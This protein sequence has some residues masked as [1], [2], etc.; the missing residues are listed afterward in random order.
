MKKPAHNQAVSDG[1]DPQDIIRVLREKAWLILACAVVGGALGSAYITRSPRIF[2]SREVVQVE[3]QAQNVINIQQVTSEELQSSEIV[4]T[5]EQN[6]V[7]LTLF[8]RVAKAN[9]LTG[10]GGELAG[11]ITAKI[12]TGTRLIDITAEDQNPEMAQKLAHSVVT[13]FVRQNA[14]ASTASTET[15]SRFLMEEAGQLKAKLE[16]SEQ[17]LQRYKEQTQAVSL[18]ERQ[19]ITV[20][21][22]K[23]LNRRVTEAKAERLRLESDSAEVQT[24]AGNPEQLCKISTVVANPALLDYRKIIATQ[25]TEVAGLSER[26][27]A[28]HPKMIQAKAQLANLRAGL[29]AEI[30]RAATA[31]VG[32]YEESKTTEQKFE[33]ALHE[34][35]QAALSLNKLSIPYNVLAREVESDRALY[36]SVLKRMKETDVT[37]GLEPNSVRIVEAASLPMAPI[38]PDKVRIFLLAVVG[39]LFLGFGLAFGFNAMDGSFKSVE[40][41]ETLLGMPVLG[42]IPQHAGD[43]PLVFRESDSRAAESFRSLRTTLSLLG[44]VENR[45]VTLFTSAAPAEGKSFCAINH[46]VSLAQQGLRTLLI[47]ADLRMPS[48]AATLLPSVKLAGLTDFLAGQATMEQVITHTDDEHLFLVAAGSR[49][50]NPAE[51]LGGADFGDLIAR[52]ATQF[53]RI[54]IDTAPV[55]AVSD[56]LLLVEHAHSVCLVVRGGKTARKSV[57]RASATLTAAGHRPV[58]VIL[59]RLSVREGAGYYYDYSNGKYG[60]KSYGQSGLAVA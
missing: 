41:A 27:R 45:K 35:E 4:K 32:L 59:N 21:K 8:D 56:T 26:Y 30:Q 46:A 39:G 40:K 6:L 14:E 25:E 38:R 13:E 20:E 53:D 19:N 33:Q 36:E 22:L 15:A 9:N 7:S 42:A 18:E 43:A 57:L 29:P 31:V 55:N 5:I 3:Q 2:A 11:R 10:G 1:I 37:R 34:Q 51:L 49:A 48:V 54:V 60:H 24:A 23:D 28:K 52:A 12:R 16:K 17:A 58:G 47:D 50:P 44:K